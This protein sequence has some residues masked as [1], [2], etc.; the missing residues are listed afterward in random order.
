MSKFFEPTEINELLRRTTV[1][2]TS[3]HEVGSGVLYK[4]APESPFVYVLLSCSMSTVL[5]FCGGQLPLWQL[6]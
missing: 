1:K 4:P 2:V 3:P 6:L 5:F